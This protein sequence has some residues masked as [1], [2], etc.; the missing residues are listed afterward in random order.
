[1]LQFQG[2][3]YTAEELTYIYSALMMIQI[4]GEQAKMLV[5]LQEKTQNMINMISSAPVPTP[6]KKPGPPGKK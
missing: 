2:E 1:M 3:Q 6:P 4:S 5:N